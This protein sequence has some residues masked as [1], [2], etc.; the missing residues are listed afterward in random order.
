MSGGRAFGAPSASRPTVRPF[1]QVQDLLHVRGPLVHRDRLLTRAGGVTRVLTTHARRHDG[2]RGCADV[3]AK[4]EIFEVSQA[5]G[6]MIS[7]EVRLSAPLLDRAD[8]LF[9]AVN[10]RQAVAV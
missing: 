2:Q 4:L 8:R 3:L 5:D 7:P 10:V 6:L 1:D 9:P